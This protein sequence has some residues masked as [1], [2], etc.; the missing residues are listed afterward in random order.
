[1]PIVFSNGE[2]VLVTF[3]GEGLVAMRDGEVLAEE[4]SSIPQSSSIA[5]PGQVMITSRV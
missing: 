5:V 2:S 4:T 3:K 1:M